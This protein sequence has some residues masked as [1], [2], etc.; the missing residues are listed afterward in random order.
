MSAWEARLVLAQLKCQSQIIVFT[1]IF[2]NSVYWSSGCMIGYWGYKEK[3]DVYY[4]V[5]LVRYLSSKL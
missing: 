3:L 5:D 4:T 1:V 2:M